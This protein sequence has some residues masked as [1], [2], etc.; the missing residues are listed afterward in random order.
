MLASSL[1]A[2]ELGDV[3]VELQDQLFEV[4]F[5]RRSLQRVN[6]LLKLLELCD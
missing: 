1:G 2:L 5:F 4:D 3:I 6:K